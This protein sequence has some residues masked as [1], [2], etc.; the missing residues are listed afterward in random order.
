M[1]LYCTC[2]SEETSAKVALQLHKFGISRV[3]PLRGGFDAWKELGYP[4]LEYT[5][6][7]PAAAALTDPATAR[8]AQ[9]RLRSSLCSLASYVKIH[10]DRGLDLGR[11]SVEKKRAIARFT[12]RLD[13]RT[14]QHLRPAR[15]LRP[16]DLSRLVDPRCNDHRALYP[17][18]FRDRRVDRMNGRKQH[19][20]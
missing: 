19:P 5:P 6:P 4:L 10:H 15:H 13:C 2:P 11:F 12:H 3:R 18:R 17:R 20:G 1:I 9:R 8:A 16:D 7:P 14:P